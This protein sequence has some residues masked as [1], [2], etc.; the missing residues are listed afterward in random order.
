MS[1]VPQPYTFF[2]NNSHGA[3]TLQQSSTFAAIPHSHTV[4]VYLLNDLN[5]L[6]NRPDKATCFYFQHN[7]S[8]T[9][10]CTIQVV[11]HSAKV[12]M[13]FAP[14]MHRLPAHLTPAIACW[15]GCYLYHCQSS[16]ALTRHLHAGC[17]R[18]SPACHRSCSSGTSRMMLVTCPALQTAET[19]LCNGV[20]QS[21][22]TDFQ[23]DCL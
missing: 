2:D 1:L 19:V 20:R 18:R 22:S 3:Q 8:T 17:I 15:H 6:C 10:L 21:Q 14:A 7:N 23:A 9:S 13:I 12:L 5:Q 16:C 4:V 11:L